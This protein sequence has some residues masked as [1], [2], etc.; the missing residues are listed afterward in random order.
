MWHGKMTWRQR[1]GCGGRRSGD[2]N[3]IGEGDLGGRCQEARGG[4]EKGDVT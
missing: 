1:R 4:S 3:N 2:N